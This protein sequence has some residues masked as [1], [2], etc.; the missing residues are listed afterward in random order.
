MRTSTASPGGSSTQAPPCGR[1]TSSRSQPSASSPSSSPPPAETCPRVRHGCP[2]TGSAGSRPDV[3]RHATCPDWPIRSRSRPPHGRGR[4]SRDVHRLRRH[5]S[6]SSGP[7]TRW[8]AYFSKRAG[9]P[10][11][12]S[13]PDGELTATY[14]ELELSDERAG[15]NGTA[16]Y[17]VGHVLA[18]NL[19]HNYE[20][21]LAQVPR[22]PKDGAFFT[23]EDDTSNCAA[24]APDVA[25]GARSVLVGACGMADFRL[26]HAAPELTCGDER[27]GLLGEE[28]KWVPVSPQRFGR[29]S[30]SQSGLSV[31]VRGTVGE[32]VVV[33]FAKR[34]AA[35][36]AE[37][38]KVVCVLPAAGVATA[39][40]PWGTCA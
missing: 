2:G 11:A 38:R 16:A 34:R 36:A 28:G 17:A 10:S 3:P 27:W 30:A 1:G 7:S 15:A 22:L 20:L 14:T 4:A 24:A 40:V 31:E 37:V 19:L 21:P 29:L 39:S 6:G 12:A 25:Q 33:R 13:G 23:W 5:Q 35:G 26:L 9:L 8:C 32:R 18:I